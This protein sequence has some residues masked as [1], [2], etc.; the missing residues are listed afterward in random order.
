MT[1]GEIRMFRFRYQFTPNVK[2]VTSLALVAADAMPRLKISGSIFRRSARIASSTA[3]HCPFRGSKGCA[4][5]TRVSI[6]FSSPV[7]SQLAEML[8]PLER[9][10][11][12]RSEEH[13]S[14]LQ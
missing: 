6:G 7:R 10:F 12:F 13:P 9:I 8:P 14:E 3:P 2:A 11:R 1:L 4:G 5:K